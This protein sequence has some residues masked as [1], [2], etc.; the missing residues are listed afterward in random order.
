MQS[1]ATIFHYLKPSDSITL[2]KGVEK[3][4]TIDPSLYFFEEVMLRK[5]GSKYNLS[6][7]GSLHWDLFGCL[8]A[9]WILI[10]LALIKGV[11]SSIY[12]AYFTAIYPYVIL[13]ILFGI[14]LSLPGSVDGIKLFLTPDLEKIQ[15]TTV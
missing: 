9:A 7:L 14:G 3:K 5:N 11:K 2:T 12:V 10:C 4:C 15:H 13:V 1:A 6:Y 8:A